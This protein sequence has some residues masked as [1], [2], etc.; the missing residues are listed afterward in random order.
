ML[1]HLII[2]IITGYLYQQFE[3]IKTSIIK[4]YKNVSSF[5][6]L[7]SSPFTFNMNIIQYLSF[8]QLVFTLY[9]ARNNSMALNDLLLFTISSFIIAIIIS[10]VTILPPT[11]IKCY[12]SKNKFDKSCN[13]KLFSIPVF[14]STIVTLILIKY[15]L[16]ET[17]YL[18]SL[19]Y[20]LGI[21]IVKISVYSVSQ[22]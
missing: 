13:N 6:I 16:M 4:K 1:L 17:K 5:D 15:K 14:I 2:I 7:N 22:S 19:W 18:A 21:Y 8:L 11:N 9:L 12:A 3:N 20:F 10:S